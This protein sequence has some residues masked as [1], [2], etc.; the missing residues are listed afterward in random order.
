MWRWPFHAPFM[1]RLTLRSQRT[2]NALNLAIEKTAL[3]RYVAPEKPS[4]VGLSREGS[5][6]RAAASSA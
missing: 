2:M 1:L 4:L 6:R 3:E 5:G